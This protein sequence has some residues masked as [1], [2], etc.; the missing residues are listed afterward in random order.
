MEYLS[1]QE[2]FTFNNTAHSIYDEMVFNAIKKSFE[3]A[4]DELEK[5]RDIDC[6]LSC[7]PITAAPPIHGFVS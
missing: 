7:T 5:T 4:H 6:L 2:P 1:F 3:E